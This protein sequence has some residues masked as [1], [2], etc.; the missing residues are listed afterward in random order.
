[1]KF[2]RILLFTLFLVP[3]VSFGASNDFMM[4]AQLLAAAKN[5]DIQQVQALVNNGAN[6][7]FVDATG[8]SIVCTALMNNDVRAAQILQMYGAD[9]SKCDSQIKSYKNR[10]KTKGGGGLFSGLSSA[11]TISLAAAG[12]AVVVGGLLLLTDVFDPGNDNDS[13]SSGGDRPSGGG[14]SGGGSGSATVAFKLPYGPALPTAK[15][16]S[17]NYTTN[18]DLYSPGDETI[19]AKNFELMTDVD[20]QNY[21]LMM[22]GYSPLAR[23]YMGMRTLRSTSTREPFDLTGLNWRGEQ[24]GGGR[25]IN[26]AVVTANGVNAN[27][28]AYGVDAT[29]SLGDTLLPWTSVNGTTLNPAD[30]TMVSSKYYNNVV[31]LG[32]GESALADAKTYEDGTM[33]DN[34]DLAGWGTAVNN[35]GASNDDNLL[36]KIVGGR[37]SGYANADYV[38]FMPNGQ[39]TIYRTGGGMGMVD[40]TT[41]STGSFELTDSKLTQIVLF[42]ETMTV[43]QTGNTFVATNNADPEK[44]YNGYIGAN[45]YLY[46]DSAAD[47]EINQA[48]S[49]STDGQLNLV[50]ELGAIDY[51]NYKALLNAALLWRAG[52]LT[53]GRSRV[54]VIANSSVISPLRATTVETIDDILSLSSDMRQAGLAALINKYYDVNTDD[55]YPGSDATN[56]FAQLGSSFQ[57]LMVFSTGG[58]ETDNLYTGKT[59]SATFENVV[60]LIY[61][62][63]ED[64]FMSVVAVELGGSGTAGTTSVSGYSPTGKIQL[65]TWADNNGTPDDTTDDKYYKARV[66]GVAGTGSGSVDPWCFAGAGH[67]DEHAVSSVAGAVGAVKSAFDYLNNRQI[68]ALLALTADGPLLATNTAGVAFTKDTLTAYLQNLYELP[69]EYQY[70]VD[71]GADYLDV[72][73]QVFGY[74]LIN[75]ERATKPGT[76]VYFYDG[77]NIVSANGNAYWRAATDTMFRPSSVLSLRES[78]IRAPFYDVLESVDGEMSLPR[79]WE[80]EFALGASDKRGLY[81]GDVL[82][83]LKTRRDN[84]ARNQVGNIG[85][86]MAFSERAYNDNMNGLD[87]LALDFQSGNWKLGASYQHYLTDGVSRFDGLANPVLGLASNAVVSDIK[88]NSGNWTF[89]ARAFSGAITDEGLLENDP[90]ISSQYMP[91]TLGLMQG[92]QSEIVWENNGLSFG[93]SVGFAHETDTILGAYTGGLLDLGAGDTM[94]IDGVAKYRVNEMINFMARATFAHTTSDASG[95]FILGMTDIN[96]NA[97]AIGANVGNFEFV[98]S[99]PLAITDGALQY[100]YADYDVIEVA[101]NKYELSVI[102][103]RIEDLNLRPEKRELRF[104]GAY[105]HKF[106]EFTDGAVGFIYRVNPNHTDDFG[107]ESIFMIKMTHRLGI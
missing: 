57:P 77:N 50:K 30:D 88:Y 27:N 65:A 37:D 71:N 29:S 38:G 62:N 43:L 12:A 28:Y 24:I 85:V 51:L 66:C 18:L 60:P 36:A 16:E 21:L 32:T 3:S 94:Y 69:G 79:V 44:Q 103:T 26:V 14:D 6:V 87:S 56:L 96:S 55:D 75:L 11:Q 74:G 84:V 4:A 48:Y 39:M 95:Q 102:D 76:S 45:G 7:N 90:T 100:A 40:A 105:R 8:L 63:A 70:S 93:A 35:A 101:D 5:A 64:Y 91:A 73:S 13:G 23:G 107:D 89:G 31:Q 98:V 47:G 80:N 42:G 34:F 54:D 83:E 2:I 52:N 46:I 81:M 61:E 106:G 1:M 67:S 22:H 19:Y 15:D 97:F 9:A 78:T 104:S 17:Q 33:L 59:L 41:E 86:S 58:F 49:M 92:A 53:G 68:F 25:P 82:A 10:N 20:G 99:Q 72:F